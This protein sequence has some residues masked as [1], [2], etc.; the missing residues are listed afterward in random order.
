MRDFQY[1]LD[2]CGVKDLSFTGEQYN[3]VNK[4]GDGD[5]IQ[6]MLDI[7]VGSY[8]WRRL[9]SN[10]LVSNLSF[11]H[12][13]HRAIQ[14]SLGS[15]WVWV[16]RTPSKKK[17]R[18]FHFKEI[19]VLDVECK[20]VVT[21]TWALKQVQVGA[22]DVVDCLR[23]Y[24]VET[25]DW[26]FKNFGRIKKEI[27][28]E[29]QVQIEKMKADNSYRQCISVI[30]DMERRLE[31]LYNQDEIYWKQRSRMEWLTHGDWN[32]KVFHR[33]A[34]ERSRRNRIT[35]LFS[36][37]GE[38]CTDTIS[39]YFQDIFTSSTPSLGDISFVIS[40]VVQKVT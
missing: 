18:R 8:D 26:G 20:E 4:H 17:K 6:E 39:G 25:D 27:N 22:V 13:D 15:S 5:F 16:R 7:F 11:Y 36:N 30:K 14:I 40:C 10:S 12:S 31:A 2:I 38:W 3:W 21:S 34:I 9:F 23:S 35:N 28:D 33:K 29:L 1:S 37:T 24:V 32:S 19:W